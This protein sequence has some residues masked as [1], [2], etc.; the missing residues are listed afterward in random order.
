MV[1]GVAVIAD[2]PITPVVVLDAP[3]PPVTPSPVVA[4]PELTPAQLRAAA[5]REAL[6]RL[7]AG[8]ADPREAIAAAAKRQQAAIQPF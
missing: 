1:E 4:V 6:A 5:R 2:E 8:H 3:P 7:D